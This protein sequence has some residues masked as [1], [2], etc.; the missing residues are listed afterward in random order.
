GPFSEARSLIWY[1]RVMPVLDGLDELAPKYRAECVKEINR[2]WED[3]RGGPLVLCCRQAEYQALPERVKLGG[4]VIVCPPGLDEI[5]RYLEAAGARWEQVRAR[6]RD[7][8][9]PGVRELLSTPLM[10]SVAVLAYRGAD[11]IELC[12]MGHP[13]AERD[14]L[15]SRYVTTVTSR[16][17]VPTKAVAQDPPQYSETQVI[18][19][20]GWLAKEMASRNETEL[21][22]HE[23]S[24]PSRWRKGVKVALG[25]GVALGVGL[26]G[27][28][29]WGGTGG[30]SGGL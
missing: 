20:L 29:T 28:L 23:W 9:E 11:P 14:R 27:G 2:F 5:D 15:W 21:W 3:H 8:I 26:A 1:H 30:V 18:R 16:D 13:G 6:L 4:A 17:Y 10:L 24:G 12:T 7:G 19:W 25:L 22:L